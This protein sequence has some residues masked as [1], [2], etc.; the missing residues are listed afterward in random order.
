M[1]PRKKC[2]NPNCEYCLDNKFA[3]KNIHSS[4][5]DFPIEE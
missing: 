2:N 4:D 1:D 5:F 3:N